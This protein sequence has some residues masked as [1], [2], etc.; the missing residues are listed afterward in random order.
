MFS[1]NPTNMAP[2]A[3]W[4]PVRPAEDFDLVVKIIG[5]AASVIAK[6]WT[7]ITQELARQGLSVMTQRGRLGGEA[8][9]FA[10]GM[11][12][13]TRPFYS[14]GHGCDI[15]VSFA[16]TT[17]DCGHVGLQ[18]GSVLLRDLPETVAEPMPP[19][20]V[21]SY[22]V[23]F[24][25]IARGNSDGLPGQG[26]AALGALFYL[27]GVPSDTLTQWAESVSAPRSFVSGLEFARISLEKRDAYSLPLAERDTRPS[28]LIS[29]EQAV[30]LGYATSNCD[31]QTACGRELLRCPEQWTEKHLDIA[32]SMVSILESEEHP[33]VQA[34]RG[35]QGKVMALLRGNDS[36]IASCFQGHTAPHVFVASD[37]PDAIRLLHEGYRLVHAQE[38]DAVGILIEESIALRQQSL[39][40]LAL[41]DLIR[42]D[43]RA[44]RHASSPLTEASSA[45]ADFDGHLDAN[46]GFVAWGATQGIVRDAVALCRN[47]GLRVAALYPKQIVP[48][49][50]D[51]LESFAKSV[52][53]VVIVESG[54]TRGYWNRLRPSFSFDY[55]LLA[56]P[57]DE[58]L[59][60]LTI[61]LREGLG[62]V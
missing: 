31:C 46:I 18:P 1:T 29:S 36:A 50:R 62:S 9:E 25:A 43:D 14:M 44:S 23:P 37:I 22:A 39:D 17:T 35:P 40:V 47:F 20:G 2:F 32:R 55:A 11:R 27:L 42:H 6:D 10:L 54:E 8:G 28:L 52:G 58:S 13:A 26:L 5:P 53:R 57:P 16:D 59:T 33:G 41:S 48:F 4:L 7:R 19:E 38:S 61:F 45:M 60:P 3:D 21:I 12:L 51:Q 30:L 56:P 15:L 49:E 34:F 24:T